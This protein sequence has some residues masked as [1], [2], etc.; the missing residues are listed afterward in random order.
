MYSYKWEN[1]L[2][3]YSNYGLDIDEDNMNLLSK[4]D[5]KIIKT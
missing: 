2:Y 5:K 1:Y 3:L 4:F